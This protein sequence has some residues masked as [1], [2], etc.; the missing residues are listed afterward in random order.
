MLALDAPATSRVLWEPSD[1]TDD[2]EAWIRSNP[3]N[4][5]PSDNNTPLVRSRSGTRGGIVIFFLMGGV[6]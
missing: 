6:S 4:N 2:D 1:N 3:L 5:P